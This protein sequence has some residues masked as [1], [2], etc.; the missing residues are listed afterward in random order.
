MEDAATGD[1]IENYSRQKM[2]S[3]D[4]M[5]DRGEVPAPFCVEKY[6]FNPHDLMGDIDYD[7]DKKNNMALPNLLKTKQ[8]FFMDKRNR[9]VN[10]FGWLVSNGHIVDRHG[11][12]KFDRKQLDDGD[13]QKLLNYSGKRFDIKDVIGVFDKDRNGNIM[14]LRSQDGTQLLDNIG[15]RVNERGY[16][17]DQDGNVIDKDG[18][19]IF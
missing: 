4:D 5:D 1:I 7:F 3:K 6:N 18:K 11:R 2:F 13:M 19:R 14:P 8:G 16:L 17:I 10:K 9:R 15:R 12:K